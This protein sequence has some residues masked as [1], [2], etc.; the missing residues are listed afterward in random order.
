MRALYVGL[1]EN[2]SMAEYSL[3]RCGRSWHTV[4]AAGK[5]LHTFE[6]VIAKDGIDT[7]IRQKQASNHMKWVRQIHGWSWR[8]VQDRHFETKAKTKTGSVKTNTKTAK[9]RS[10][11]DSRPRPQSRG[12]QDCKTPH[13]IFIRGA[14]TG[15]PGAQ[16]PTLEKIRVGMAHN[17]NFR[18]GLKT[19]WQ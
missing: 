4:H 10:Q 8:I 5:T 2:A 12:L 1:H 17:G 9:N 15:G 18:R 6:L 7:G 3:H 19:S 11:V 14:G 16:V 13:S